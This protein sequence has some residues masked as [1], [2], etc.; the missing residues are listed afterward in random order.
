MMPTDAEDIE[1]KDILY[2]RYYDGKQEEFLRMLVC[3]EII[4]EHRRSP[5]GQH[6]EPL[7]RL[8]L[9][10]RRMPMADKLAIKRDETSS[11]FRLIAFSG[12]RGVPPRFVDDTAYTTVEEAYHAIFLRQ[13]KDLQD[14]K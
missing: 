6:S 2:R 10:F 13:I 14:S 4:E 7:E 5:L 12:K 8:L 3:D 11:R 1:N 9:H